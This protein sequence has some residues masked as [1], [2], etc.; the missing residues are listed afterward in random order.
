M[1]NEAPRTYV[2]SFIELRQDMTP[3]TSPRAVPVAAFKS[4]LL[5]HQWFS[6]NLNHWVAEI[7][8]RLAFSIGGMVL[9]AAAVVQPAD[10]ARLLTISVGAAERS[11]EVED[12]ATF[13]RT[14]EV[15]RSLNWYVK[16]FDTEQVDEFRSLLGTKFEIE[17]LSV[18]RFVN[19]PLGNILLERLLVLFRSNDTEA[20]LKA[21]RGALVLAAFD[22]EEGFTILNVIQKWPLREVE[23]DLNVAL[24][25]IE[26]AEQVFVEAKKISVHLRDVRAETVEAK[27]IQGLPDFRQAGDREWTQQLLRFP[28]PN[29]AGQQTILAD[30]YLPSAGDLPAPLVVIS[31]GLGSNRTT[32]RY[33]AEHL[34]SHGM[35]V[36]AIEHPATNSSTF[37]RVLE[38]FVT[39]L[40]TDVFLERPRDISLLVDRL[41]TRTAPGGSLE[42]RIDA[43]KVGV[44][45]QSLGGY[46][47]LALG[48]AQLDINYLRQRCAA[49]TQSL[50]FNL[51]FE[52]QCQLLKAEPLQDSYS[53]TDERVV[54]VMALNPVSSAVFG[55][56]GM[57]NLQIPVTIVAGDND[58][59]AP[60]IPEQVFPYVWT[61][62]E[63]KYLLYVVPGTHFS[64]LGEESIARSNHRLSIMPAEAIGPDPKVAQLIL[65]GLS[66]AFFQKYLAGNSDAEGM[67]T[68]AYL[69]TLNQPP[70]NFLL[71]D[72]LSLE[73]I[74]RAIAT[75]LSD[76][77]IDPFP[78]P[79]F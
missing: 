11:L 68:N 79:F 66:T 18:S 17:P 3:K 65:Q 76:E 7:T 54:S 53:L 28:N 57:K 6:G 20:T 13:V 41:E 10:A 47:A 8:K 52:L 36:A 5:H 15:P 56:E 74:D 77:A 67:F 14:D 62:G 73:D 30:L 72:S 27:Q 46:T 51:S 35:A 1:L 63:E 69:T 50:P 2:T 12:L 4:R 22:D 9:T 24:D 21:L 39:P 45:G 19:S 59:F 49:S 31:H 71:S 40:E 78:V 16:R 29:R 58:F 44:L 43:S 32:F 26:E 34:A 25:A 61:G 38:G 48:G 64:F 75:P 23:L 55:P 33:L 37:D 60:A 70:F 42:G